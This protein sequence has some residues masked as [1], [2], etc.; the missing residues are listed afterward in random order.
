M[1]PVT[2]AFINVF[3]ENGFECEVVEL[4]KEDQVRIPMTGDPFGPRL[5]VVRFLHESNIVAVVLP[6]L[7]EIPKGK[8]SIAI[9]LANE[10]HRSSHLV[11]LWVD[12]KNRS[13]WAMVNTFAREPDTVSTAVDAVGL[14]MD[15]CSRMFPVIETTLTE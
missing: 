11:K 8:S 12:K 7:I 15:Y 13:L 3:K 9:K 10:L 14:L 5:L 2:E 1:L 4:E 6:D